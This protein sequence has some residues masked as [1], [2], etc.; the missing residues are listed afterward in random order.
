VTANDGARVGDVVY[1]TKP[2]GMGAMT[3][4]AKANKISFDE[5]RPA[6]LQMATLNAAAAEAMT[7]AGA[8][9]CTDVTGFGLVGHARNVGAASA[10][11]LRL[12][13]GDVPLFPGTLALARAGVLSGGAKR[14]RKA[15]KDQVTV[16]SGVD[17]P[18]VNLLFDAETSGGLLIVLP[19]AR[20]D[21]LERELRE[22]SL[23]VHQVGEVV[24][25][26]GAHV[27][28]V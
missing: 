9:A 11:T 20:A 13:S 8:H 26:T 24:A 15:L 18:L 19:A 10:V 25:A 1:L 28:V 16:A 2:I 12:R 5:L 6:A 17:E 22:R 3:T 27:D 7:A 21:E 14:G 23:P 4:G